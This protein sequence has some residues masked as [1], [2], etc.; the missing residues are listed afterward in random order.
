MAPTSTGAAGKLPPLTTGQKWITGFLAAASTALA[1]LAFTGMYTSVRDAMVPF[2]GRLA[3]IVPIGADLG[4]VI[5]SVFSVFFEIL[6]M[7][8]WWLRWVVMLF[9]GVQVALNIGTAHGNPLGSAG[10]GVLPL[11]FVAT[12]EVWQF[13]IR[14]RR[15]LIKPRK[16]RE[17]RER[18]PFA[19]YMAS[20]G[21]SLELRRC[22][23]LWGINTIADALDMMQRVKRAESLLQAHFGLMWYSETPKHL[24][25]MLHTAKFVDDAIRE[26][27]KLTR[28]KPARVNTGGGPGGG[29]ATPKS[30]RTDCC[31]VHR[32]LAAETRLPHDDA[33]AIRLNAEHIDVHGSAIGVDT[34][35][36]IFGLGTAKARILRDALRESGSAVGSVGVVESGQSVGSGRVA[37]PAGQSVNGNHAGGG[38]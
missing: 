2:L 22:M 30:A 11:L 37:L 19:R 34:L 9:V 17:R 8:A 3:W 14:R 38:G 26:I 24:I 7:P 28:E 35:R 12:V 21:G 10:H 4:M 27:E 29:A 31:T 1:T 33:T 25:H 36:L 20:W 13:F 16:K 32:V 15:N 5:F 18:I 6:D 23:I